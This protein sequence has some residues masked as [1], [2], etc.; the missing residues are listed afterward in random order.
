MS[1]PQNMRGIFDPKT[2]GEIFN[3]VRG[4]SSL[5]ALC[6]S[7]PVSFTGNKEF[8]FELDGEADIVGE[9]GAKSNGGLTA[10]PVTVIPYKFDYGARVSDEFMNATEEER[11]DILTGFIEGCAKKFASGFDQAAMHGINPRTGSASSVVG[12]NHFDKAVTATVT[13]A[14]ATADDSIDAAISAIENADRDVSGVILSPAVRS[15]LSAMR[16]SAGNR[17]YPEFA[18]G[19]TPPTLGSQ[20]LTVNKTVSKGGTDKGLVGDF[21]NAFKWGYAKEMNFEIIPYGNPDNSANGD[22]KGHGQVYLRCECYIGWAILDG[23]S[24]CRLV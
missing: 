17:L 24:F 10:S 23:A 7:K 14:A 9:S 11:L 20:R 1:N 21:A 19:G 15:D 3:K 5:A 8:T 13:Y 18:F 16:S 12:N 22:L 4:F 2:T 6:A